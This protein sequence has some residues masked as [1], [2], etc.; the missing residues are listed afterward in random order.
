[1]LLIDIIH[2]DR[3]PHGYRG[4]EGY[5]CTDPRVLYARGLP[6]TVH[7]HGYTEDRGARGRLLEGVCR[8]WSSSHYHTLPGYVRYRTSNGHRGLAPEQQGQGHD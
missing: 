4:Y 8:G 2:Q 6:D 5:R 3:G 7:V 1:M